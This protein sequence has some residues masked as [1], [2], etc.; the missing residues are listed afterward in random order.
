MPKSCEAAV[1]PMKTTFNPT[2]EQYEKVCI[3]IRDLFQGS[4]SLRCVRL[5]TTGVRLALRFQYLLCSLPFFAAISWS[6]RL[7]VV[8]FVFGYCVAR[9]TLAREGPPLVCRLLPSLFRDFVRHLEKEQVTPVSVCF[10]LCPCVSCCDSHSNRGAC[11][12]HE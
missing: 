8:G 9:Q 2:V 7:L 4:C 11:C 6:I 10:S 3:Q 5:H 12:V 1:F